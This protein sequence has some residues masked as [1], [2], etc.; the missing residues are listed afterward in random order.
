M[1]GPVSS[2]FFP[3]TLTFGPTDTAVVAPGPFGQQTPITT[4]TTV[5]PLPVGI[6]LCTWAWYTTNSNPGTAQMFAGPA[7]GALTLLRIIASHNQAFYKFPSHLFTN[8]S[9]GLKDF[10]LTHASEGASV[11][12][13]IAGDTRFGRYLTVVRVG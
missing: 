10:A 5:D 11:T 9:L 7:G 1:L 13:G 12:Y 2:K 3:I 4:F 6:Y 8:T